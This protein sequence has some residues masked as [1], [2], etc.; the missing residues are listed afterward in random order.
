MLNTDLAREGVE[1]RFVEGVV[2]C[3]R[4]LVHPYEAFL[5]INESEPEYLVETRPRAFSELAVGIDRG[6]IPTED[7]R[8][9]QT[10]IAPV[11]RTAAKGEVVHPRGG[12]RDDL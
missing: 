5:G 3:S 2:E 4:D 11:F 10:G 9:R 12:R 8:P 7:K 6:T 1:K